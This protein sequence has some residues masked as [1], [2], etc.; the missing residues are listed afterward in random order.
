MQEREAKGAYIGAD[1]G[2]SHRKMSKTLTASKSGAAR[3]AA[4]S[5]SFRLMT[6]HTAPRSCLGIRARCYRN[7]PQHRAS[8]AQYRFS[9]R[10]ASAAIARQW[11]SRLQSFDRARLQRVTACPIRCGARAADRGTVQFSCRVRDRAG[12]RSNAVSAGPDQKRRTGFQV[13]IPEPIPPRPTQGAGSP[14]QHVGISPHSQ[15]SGNALSISEIHS[16]IEHRVL[17]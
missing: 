17:D 12:G 14:R 6:W 15:R 1:K 13:G 3:S 10:T 8:E 16:C 11:P 2:G 9:A 5:R 4:I 7:T